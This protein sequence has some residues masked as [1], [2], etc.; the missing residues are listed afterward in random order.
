MKVIEAWE[1]YCDFC[2]N[3]FCNFFEV[4]W[5]WFIELTL[6]QAFFVIILFCVGIWGLKGLN[7]GSENYDFIE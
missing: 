4:S 7:E 2:N 5:N 1:M 6:I 3:I